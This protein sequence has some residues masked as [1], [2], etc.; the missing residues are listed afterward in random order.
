[1]TP[2]F[3]PMVLPRENDWSYPEM[4]EDLRIRLEQARLCGELIFHLHAVRRYATSKR[5]NTT[6]VFSGAGH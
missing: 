4:E 3:Y 6:R 2:A 1:M 5:A